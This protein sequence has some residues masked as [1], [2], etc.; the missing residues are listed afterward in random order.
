M[1]DAC[2]VQ[3]LDWQGALQC[4]LTGILDLQDMCKGRHAV[5]DTAKDVV[6]QKADL[7]ADGPF[8]SS[9][10][11]SKRYHEHSLAFLTF[12]AAQK[13]QG[14]PDARRVSEHLDRRHRAQCLHHQNHEALFRLPARALTDLPVHNQLHNATPAD[15]L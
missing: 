9:S 3:C 14:S 15:G 5:G 8:H 4:P 12:V 13:Q 1:T 6:P 7:D 11:V 2:N 10:G